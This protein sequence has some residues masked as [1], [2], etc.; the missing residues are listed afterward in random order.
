MNVVARNWWAVLVRGV[1]G[2]AFGAFALAMPVVAFAVIILGFGAYALVD[3][4]FNIVAALR[5][6]RGERGWWPLLLSGVAVVLVGLAAF[7]APGL[8]AL[9]MLYVIPGWAILPGVLEVAAAIRLR[10]HI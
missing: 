8:T 4:A 5:D 6:A 1:L 10:R 7:A 9:V 2:M 3:G